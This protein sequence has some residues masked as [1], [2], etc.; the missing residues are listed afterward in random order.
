MNTPNN[1][2]LFNNNLFKQSIMTIS[3]LLILISSMTLILNS[4]ANKLDKNVFE[5]RESILNVTFNEDI[6]MDNVLDNVLPKNIEIKSKYGISSMSG[7]TRIAEIDEMINIEGEFSRTTAKKEFKKEVNN[8]L[9]K[10]DIIKSNGTENLTIRDEKNVEVKISSDQKELL[11]KEL[12]KFSK[13]DISKSKWKYLW[14]DAKILSISIIGSKEVIGNIEIL[15]KNTGHVKNSELIVTK[16]L[17]SKLEIINNKVEVEKLKAEKNNENKTIEQIFTEVS[18]VEF[19]NIMSKEQKQEIEKNKFLSEEKIKKIDNIIAID[20]NNYY[21][22]D[23]NSLDLLEFSKEEKEKIYTLIKNYN[24]VP[25]YEKTNIQSEIK[26]ITMQQNIF[27]IGMF[28]DII[29]G[30]ESEI[31]SKAGKCERETKVYHRWWGKTFDLN[32][33]VVADILYVLAAGGLA[34]TIGSFLPC[35]VICG[36]MAGFIAMHAAN[37]TWL[38]YH[39]GDNG[40]I[41]HLPWCGLFAM[42]RKC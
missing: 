40:I 1:S 7:L 14:G 2:K 31:T 27:T 33:C 36:V 18:E 26:A 23:S 22:L 41:I 8:F 19:S 6:Y 4:N 29:Y 15:L 37:I 28:P 16:E 38:N 24:N 25:N 5:T 3:I 39:C 32:N 35:G 11:N 21:S 12:K 17:Q 30:V 9:T 34:F 20:N 42:G 13:S 10:L